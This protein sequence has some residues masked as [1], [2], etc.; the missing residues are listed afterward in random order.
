MTKPLLDDLVREA[1]KGDRAAMDRLLRAVSPRMRTQLGSYGLG[2]EDRADA[3]QNALLQVVRH[4]GAFRDD[5]KLSTWIFRITENEALMVLRGRRRRQ[6]RTVGGLG[7][8]ELGNLPAM[9]DTR[10]SDLAICAARK[11]AKVHREM[12]RLPPHYRDVLVAHYMDDLDLREASERLGVTTCAVRSRLF[13]ARECMRAA[14]GPA[15][16]PTV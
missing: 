16:A 7:L 15:E 2:R 6:G 13:R 4:L 8:D 9:Q 11:G 1:A 12:A 14:L 5:A 3:L 10:D